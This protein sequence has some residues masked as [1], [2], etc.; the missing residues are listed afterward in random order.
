M[1]TAFVFAP[2]YGCRSCCRDQSFS[3]WQASAQQWSTWWVCHF[4]PICICDSRLRPKSKYPFG[5]K[6]LCVF[7]PCLL[8]C[9]SSCL[10]P[11]VRAGP[12]AVPGYCSQ[13]IYPPSAY[14]QFQTSFKPAVSKP[15]PS[16]RPR[17][18]PHPKGCVQ[19]QH[20]LFLN[21]DLFMP[22]CH[23]MLSLQSV[24]PCAVPGPCWYQATPFLSLPCTNGSRYPKLIYPEL[25][26][27][28]A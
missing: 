21:S 20:A 14:C 18:A 22:L 8:I 19:L 13:Y 1:L 25:I 11:T 27:T 16:R 5:T 2:T 10:T 17:Q 15:M 24:W 12:C 4:C 7:C 6:G 28:R 3:S 26:Q 9:T 23:K